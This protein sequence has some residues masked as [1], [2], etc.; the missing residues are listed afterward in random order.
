[1]DDA[2]VANELATSCRPTGRAPAAGRGAHVW[3]SSLRAQPLP[4]E[5]HG[6][7]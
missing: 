3:W 4:R 1:M 6:G 7:L 5:R 2:S